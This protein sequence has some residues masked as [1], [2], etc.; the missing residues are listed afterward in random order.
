MIIFGLSFSLFMRESKIGEA[1]YYSLLALSGVLGWF[2]AR[3]SAFFVL[4][5]H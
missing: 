5:K 4:H 3:F 2:I 1:T